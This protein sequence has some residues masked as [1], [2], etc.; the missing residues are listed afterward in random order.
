M[1]ADPLI[2][3]TMNPAT[4]GNGNTSP[5]STARSNTP[6]VFTQW[7]RPATPNAMAAAWTTTSAATR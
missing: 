7:L 6:P 1:T 2:P 4:S 3:C 5:S